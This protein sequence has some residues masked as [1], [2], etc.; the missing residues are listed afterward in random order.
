M[1][2]AFTISADGH[3]FPVLI[4]LPRLTSLPEYMP[5]PNI[6]LH[7]SSESTFNGKIIAENYI[8][9]ILVSY[10]KANELKKTAFFYDSAPCHL[11]KDVTDTLNKNDIHQVYDTT[12]I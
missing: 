8:E 11:T 7:Y 4:I 1:S 10:M 9:R 12:F 2:C 3:K 6:A 5:P